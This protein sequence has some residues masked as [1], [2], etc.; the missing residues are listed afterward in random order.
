MQS[1]VYTA[2]GNPTRVKLLQC[3]GEK[4]K[5][6][7]ELINSCGLSQSAVSQHLAKLKEAGLVVAR[8]EGQVVWYTVKSP[9]ITLQV[10]SM[11]S[12]LSRQKNNT[13]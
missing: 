11:I 3:L 1:D 5:S 2:L 4:P 9:Q 6:V 12:A 10:C 8:K 7:T 13:T